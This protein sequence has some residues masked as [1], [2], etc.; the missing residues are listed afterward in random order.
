MS[1]RV[2][3][4]AICTVN[5]VDV[6]V[7]WNFRHLANVHRERRIAMVNESWGYVYPLRIASPPEV[8]N[9]GCNHRIKSLTRSPGME[10][11]WLAFMV[12]ASNVQV[13]Y[14]AEDGST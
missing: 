6:L 1:I 14:P 4:V 5:E 3:H 2:L 10:S 13:V 8:M 11:G 9:H 12:F 7:S